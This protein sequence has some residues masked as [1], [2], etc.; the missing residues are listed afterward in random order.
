[1]SYAYAR[2]LLVTALALVAPALPLSAEPVQDFYRGKVITLIVGAD[3]SGEYTT[4]ARLLARHMGKHIPGNPTIIIQNMPGASSINATNYLYEVAAK[5]GTVLGLPSKDVALYQ[6][7]RMPNTRY[8]VQN[9]SWLGSMSGSNNLLVVWSGTGVEKIADARKREVIMGA[10]ARNGTL[11]TYPLILN[12]IAGTKFKL[13]LGY[14]GSQVIDL[15]MQRGEV[16][17]KGSYSWANLKRTHPDWVREK[18]L[19]ILVQF[20]LQKEP[21]LPNVPLVTE[22]AKNDQERAVLSLISSDTVMA[23]PVLLPPNVPAER[24]AA[25]RTAFDATM[26]DPDFL[27]EAR[28]S[29]VDIEPMRGDDLQA[30]IK[31]IVDTP[32]EIIDIAQ[33]WMIQE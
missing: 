23:R 27:A 12:A 7:S 22:F 3:V 10:L 18:K 9:F 33:Q 4:S 29:R 25:M 20:G 13:V 21:D 11:A 15:A 28:S 2:L 31:R 19:N 1:M 5:D 24:V 30:L 8:K 17:G 14:V 6:A 16:E 26:S 32:P